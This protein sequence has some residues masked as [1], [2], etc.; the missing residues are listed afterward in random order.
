[1]D[2]NFA[3]GGSNSSNG[4][5]WYTDGGF[6]GTVRITDR[7]GLSISVDARYREVGGAAI[8]EIE[9]TDA[10]P[11][12][13]IAPGY[14]GGLSWTVTPAFVIAF[15]GSWDLAA[16]GFPI[17]GQVTSSLA[18][19]VG[20]WTFVMANQVGYYNGLNVDYS[21]FQYDTDVDQTICKNGLQAIYSFNRAF[22]DAGITYTNFLNNAAVS[23]YWSPVAGIGV[24]FS[25]ASG[26]RLGYHGDFGPGFD[27][28][29]ADLQFFFA[30]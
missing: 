30:Y 27:N 9:N 8:Y 26:V 5:G 19:E 20:P 22:V 15:G 21:D 14:G 2:L 7:I 16:G 18:Y 3:A 1:M 17:G 11:I 28:N 23:E 10:L 24:H 29:G 4:D 13:L 12:L 6:G 25:R